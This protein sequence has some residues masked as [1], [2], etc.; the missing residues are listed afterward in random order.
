MGCYR[1]LKKI[2]FIFCFSVEI[3]LI[4][5]TLFF[6][7]TGVHHYYSNPRLFLEASF[8]DTDGNSSCVSC[9]TSD[10]SVP[11]AHREKFQRQDCAINTRLNS[12]KSNCLNSRVHKLET[13]SFRN[14]HGRSVNK[15]NLTA[16][17]GDSK[18]IS[19]RSILKNSNL[20]K[21]RF[22][23]SVCDP[24]QSVDERDNLSIEQS[25]ETHS[26]KRARFNNLGKRNKS[27]LSRG[28]ESPILARVKRDPKHSMALADHI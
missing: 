16:K 6:F 26:V 5:D 1:I 24:L 20:K 15:E 2:R 9:G 3:F 21:R 28:Y 17:D 22:E 27:F 11:R 25:G 4:E 19:T 18:P 23:I 7:V 14:S 10:D 12:D 8:P 13:N